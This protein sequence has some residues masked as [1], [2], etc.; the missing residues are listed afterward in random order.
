MSRPAIGQDPPPSETIHSREGDSG[1][2]ETKASGQPADPSDQP[3]SN[4][5]EKPAA[6]SASQPLPPPSGDG[7]GWK[8][9]QLSTAAPQ[10]TGAGSV[11]AI[12]AAGPL[13]R[14]FKKKS[15]E[16]ELERRK[17]PSPP[18]SNA[19]RGDKPDDREEVSSTKRFAPAMGGSWV[20]RDNPGVP[21]V[22][23]PPKGSRVSVESA[24]KPSP[25]PRAATP[26]PTEP[27]D[28]PETKEEDP[29]PVTDPVE[30]IISQESKP[31]SMELVAPGQP[32]EPSANPAP[33]AK[34]SP[35]QP[36]S[37]SPRVASSA[38]GDDRSPRKLDTPSASVGDL[39]APPTMIDYTGR[40]T[41]RIRLTRTVA[42]MRR[43]IEATL[44]YFY[45]RPEVAT[46]RS[47][48]GMMHSMMVFGPDTKVQVGNKRHSTIAWIAGNNNCRGQRLLTQDASGL[49]AKS[50]VGLQGHQG[51]FLA[52]L[53]MCH[54]PPEYPL[55]AGKNKYSVAELIE[56]EQRACRS[57]VELTFT[58]IGLSHYLDTDSTWVSDDGEQWDFER[59]LA[60]ELDQPIVGAACGGTHRLMGYAHALRK[61]R[62]E[63]KPITG[64]W[65][66]AEVYTNDFT[67]FAY[68]LQNRDGS[69][70]TGWFEGRADNGDVDRKIQTTGHIVEWL[71]TVTPDSQLQNPRLVS[72]VNFLLRSLYRD[73]GHD[74][75]IG[76]KGHALRSL[77]MYH[78]RVF[79]THKPWASAS[80]S[81]AT[82]AGTRR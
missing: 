3:T 73:L 37:V 39:Q 11:R 4:D 15:T 9:R 75:S 28:A 80:R 76:P 74:W 67:S 46:G 29:K 68:S 54:V 12:P 8:P 44:T 36:V 31:R 40:P 61:R 69:M 43:G 33:K 7:D 38:S 45:Q 82:R 47:N 71:L 18:P 78:Q 25:S 58:L 50:G 63:G 49:M 77:S 64:Q 26:K 27:K 14:F 10:T 79:R 72:A 17:A 41:G 56:A 51:Q 2:Q 60:E 13:G 5:P 53:G 66:R 30:K 35:K 20:A 52:V 81:A 6:K 48:W 57:G 1:R 32:E 16:K 62:A 65:K 55:H 70:S 21:S 24:K 23:V 59:L 22:E 34:K 19:F 42:Q